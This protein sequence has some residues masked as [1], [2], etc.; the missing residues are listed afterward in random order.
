[1]VRPAGS[2]ASAH[3]ASA[4]V[5]P[6]SR[7]HLTTVDQGVDIFSFPLQWLTGSLRTYEGLSSPEDGLLG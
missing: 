7:D 4:W 6:A 2:L 3:G 1:M 5:S